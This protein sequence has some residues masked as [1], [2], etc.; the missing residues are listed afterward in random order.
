MQDTP[1]TSQTELWEWI[2]LQLSID[3]HMVTV[4][5][6]QPTRGASRVLNRVVNSGYSQLC[7]INRKIK[8]HR[9]DSAWCRL[10]LTDA[11]RLINE[12]CDLIDDAEELIGDD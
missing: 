5:Q 4:F 1:T 11:Q 7:F 6:E 2:R 3:R 10:N 9:N 12:T 8:Q